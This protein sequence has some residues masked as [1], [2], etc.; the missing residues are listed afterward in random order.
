MITGVRNNDK[1]K[2]SQ[3]PPV[4]SFNKR[5]TNK[6]NIRYRIINGSAISYSFG[7]VMRP[8]ALKPLLQIDQFFA[9]LTI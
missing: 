3:K 7:N 1:K 4:R 9:L 8:E 6:Q 2:K 5:A